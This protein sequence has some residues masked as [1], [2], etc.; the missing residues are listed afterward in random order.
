MKFKLRHMEIFRAVMITGSI[1]GA[2]RMLHTSQPGLSKTIS[3][4]ENNLGLTLF[5]RTKSS[6]IPTKEAEILFSEISNLF[7]SALEI[8]NLVDDLKKSQRGGI[9]FASTPSLALTLIPSAILRFRDK[10]PNTNIV[11]RTITVPEINQQLLG[12]KSEFVVSALPVEHPNLIC[13]NLF[14]SNIVCLMPKG[15]P[16]ESFGVID[17]TKVSSFPIILHDRNTLYG[18]MIRTHLG[19]EIEDAQ[20]II[21]VF[22]TEQVCALV[23]AGLGISFVAEISTSEKI[24]SNV[25]TRPL[26]QNISLP[27]TLIR[28][29]F[30]GLSVQAEEFITQIKRAATS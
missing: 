7:T 5:L 28:S 3:Y 26:V 18:Q 1:S 10:L 21:E 19:Q 15:H 20:A 11:F 6:L 4:L 24:W 13:E 27:I 25:V 12:G 16:L 2:A 29:A 23:Q 9:S 30:N 8:D 14:M 22:R 17:I